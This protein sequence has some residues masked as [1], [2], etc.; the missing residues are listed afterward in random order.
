MTIGSKGGDLFLSKAKGLPRLSIEAP[1]SKT[2]RGVVLVGFT[3]TF[4]FGR[5]SKHTPICM[6]PADSHPTPSS[7]QQHASTRKEE[8]S[9]PAWKHCTHMEGLPRGEWETV[10]GVHLARVQ[11]AFNWK[12]LLVQHPALTEAFKPQPQPRRGGGF[13]YF[14]WRECRKGSCHVRAPS[15][16]AWMKKS[17]GKHGYVFQTP[18]LLIFLW[19]GMFRF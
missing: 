3:R 8:G 13:L 17:V 15:V 7:I 1:S 19:L 4:I 12:K 2:R 9:R 11:Q 6:L 10:W 16:T 18:H 14:G 5:S